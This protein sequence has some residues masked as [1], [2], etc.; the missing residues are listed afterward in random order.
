MRYRENI[1]KTSQVPLCNRPIKLKKLIIFSVLITYIIIV[2]SGCAPTIKTKKLVPAKYHEAAKLK[3]ISVLPFDGPMGNQV[4][5]DIEALLLTIL[6]NDEQYFSII[7]R[8]AIDKIFLEQSL[9]LSGAVNET[10]A[11][12]IGKLAGV[13]GI[14]MGTVTQSTIEENPYSVEKSKCISKGKNGKCKEWQQYRVNCRERN[15]YFS[16]T[17]K[18]IDVATGEIAASEAL[19]GHVSH[20]TCSDSGRPL[21]SRQE[22][23][24][25]AKKYALEKLGKLVAPYN[26][27]FEIKLLIKDDSKVPPEAKKNINDGVKWAKAGRVDRACEFWN[28][29]SNLHPY[30]YAIYYL[31]GV[32]SELSG[33]LDK[34]LSY[35]E[36]ADT[37]AS[38][39]VDEISEAIGRITI[40]IEKQKKIDEV[41]NE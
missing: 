7:E 9:Q 24:A 19:S 8:N 38:S 5:A 37:N 11:V 17:P 1:S 36:K 28:E 34:A 26:E 23:L 14:V 12:E 27:D 16:F 29:A 22:L 33:D 3:R 4:R 2:F 15:A 18:F 39:P 6:V 10:T 30:G 21:K 25:E 41:L 35:Y 40:S 32:C 20:E 13:Q 31:L